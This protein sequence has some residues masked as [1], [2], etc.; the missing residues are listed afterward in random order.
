MSTLRT[1]PTD[2]EPDK[3]LAERTSLF[4][5]SYRVVA[6]LTTGMILLQAVFAGRFLF[7]DPD[8]VDVHEV[9]A[10][11]L[12]GVVL[13]Q[14]GIA[15]LAPF[16]NRVSIRVWTLCLTVLIIAQTGLGYAGRDNSDLASLHVP[17]GVLLFG[18]SVL[19]LTLSLSDGERREV[20][21]HVSSG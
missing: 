7:V 8:T 18:I 14:L 5:T 16:T 4:V 12:S 17:L 19:V 15:L 10:N 20:R 21:G 2:Q 3:A 9:V 13:A 6:G 1:A 11:I